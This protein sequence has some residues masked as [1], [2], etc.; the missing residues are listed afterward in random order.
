M[1]KEVQYE[2]IPGTLIVDRAA[3]RTKIWF[4]SNEGICQLRMQ[5]LPPEYFDHTPIDLNYHYM[6]EQIQ[7]HFEYELQLQKQMMVALWEPIFNN[8]KSFKQWRDDNGTD[9]MIS[10]WNI[11]TRYSEEL[12][13]T[14]NIF[15]IYKSYAEYEKHLPADYK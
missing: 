8:F 6:Q 11:L 14:E 3:P 2:E 7:V 15:T 9:I 10:T 1:Q 13:L 4:N 5:D 12:K